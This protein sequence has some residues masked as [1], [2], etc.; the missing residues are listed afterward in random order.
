MFPGDSP[1]YSGAIRPREIGGPD[2][3]EVLSLPSEHVMNYFRTNGRPRGRCGNTPTESEGK[4]QQQQ[5]RVL[6]T[7]FLCGIVC[8]WIND[9]RTLCRK[10]TPLLACLS[11]L[12]KNHIN[13]RC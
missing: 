12:E 1:Y 11:E 13:V 8:V 9:I 3:T 6:F 7:L 4:G 2:G 5:P 10:H